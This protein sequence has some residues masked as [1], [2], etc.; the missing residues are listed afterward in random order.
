MNKA[1]IKELLSETSW[2]DTQYS[3]NGIE[4]QYYTT[5]N[6]K[7]NRPLIIKH[8]LISDDIEKPNPEEETHHGQEF[9]LEAFLLPNDKSSPEYVGMVHYFMYTQSSLGNP[10]YGYV[11]QF[12]VEP[13]LNSV[14]TQEMGIGTLLLDT[15]KSHMTQNSLNH[16]KLHMWPDPRCYDKNSPL[17]PLEQL[18]VIYENMGMK[19]DKETKRKMHIDLPV[20]DYK[21]FEELGLEAIT[22]TLTS[23]AEP[24][25]TCPQEP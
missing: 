18:Q 14:K 25:L 13:E 11:M 1:K 6:K 2:S 5:H 8:T 3:K 20:Q 22:P 21:T 16:F 4:S 10:P 23:S 24:Q 19:K 15:V 12:R 9:A 17:T 7:L